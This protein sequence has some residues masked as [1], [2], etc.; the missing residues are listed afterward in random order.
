MNKGDY[1]SELHKHL[2]TMPADERDAAMRFYMEY[3]DDAGQDN[4]QEVMQQLG[5]PREL[6]DQLLKDAPANPIEAAVEKVSKRER[7]LTPLLWTLLVLGSPLIIALGGVAGGLLATLIALGLSLFIVV[8]CI[9]II[10]LMVSAVF[11]PAGVYM[12]FTG[13]LV[14]FSDFATMLVFVGSGTA[15]SAF[16]MLMVK[17]C[18][19][20]LKLCS[21]GVFRASGALT[22]LLR[23]R[24]AKTKKGGE[25]A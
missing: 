21:R 11:V 7:K 13:L 15:L 19:W 1:L 3:F 25:R 5:T 24:T 8:L 18:M 22:R 14:T 2:N 12:A 17:P 9:G 16:G 4:E 20:L 6:A 10:P 23:R